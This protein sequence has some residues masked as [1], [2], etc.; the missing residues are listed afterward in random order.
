MTKLE[1]AYD[2]S[3]TEK[4]LTKIPFHGIQFDNLPMFYFVKCHVKVQLHFYKFK[5]FPFF[6]KASFFISSDI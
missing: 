1:G 3:P 5:K 2:A 6:K 4:E